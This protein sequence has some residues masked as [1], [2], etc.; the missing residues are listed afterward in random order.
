VTRLL[1]VDDVAERLGVTKDWVWAQARAW[2]ELTGESITEDK[3]RWKPYAKHVERRDPAAHGSICGFPTGE[4]IS[5]E[6]ANESIAATRA[7]TA[8]LLA[9]FERTMN[10]LVNEH[11]QRMAEEDDWRS[12]RLLT[13]RPASEASKRIARVIQ[14]PRDEQGMTVEDLAK[15][16]RFHPDSIKRMESGLTEPSLTM[17]TTLAK[18]FAVTV[19]EL[20]ARADLD[21]TEA[22]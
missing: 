14:Q 6:D 11:Q 13:S 15:A 19:A 12:L 9:T 21:S 1:T 8:Y 4:P 3:E 17:L 7:M 2:Q 5:A 18:A 20:V 22:A 10:E 16:S